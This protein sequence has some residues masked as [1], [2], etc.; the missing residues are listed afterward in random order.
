MFKIVEINSTKEA[1][2]HFVLWTPKEVWLHFVLWT[3]GYHLVLWTP[4]EAWLECLRRRG[5]ILS[6]EPLRRRGYHLVLWT[7]N[8]AVK[9]FRVGNNRATKH[10]LHQSNIL[11]PGTMLGMRLVVHAVMLCT[12]CRVAQSALVSFSCWA[13]WDQRTWKRQGQTPPANEGQWQS[14]PSCTL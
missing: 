5:S 11:I 4:K 10:N 7:I 12:C 1:W 6:F 14:S 13:L 8:E 9:S 2:L 3:R